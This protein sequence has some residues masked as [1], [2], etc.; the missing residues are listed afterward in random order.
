MT[1][2]RSA[3]DPEKPLGMSTVAWRGCT[4]PACRGERRRYLDRPDLPSDQTTLGS[5]TDDGGA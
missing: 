4:C 1:G 5:I 3:L 2:Q